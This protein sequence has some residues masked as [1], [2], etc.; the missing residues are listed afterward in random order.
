MISRHVGLL[1]IVVAVLMATIGDYWF[2]LSAETNNIGWRFW[3][4]VLIYGASGY[5]IWVAYK[6]ASWFEVGFLW[7][8]IGVAIY[9]FTGSALIHDKMP[10]GRWIAFLLAGCAAALW[11]MTPN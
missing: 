5:P 7:T 4:G 2:K 1:A 11:F 8:I 9:I 3:L 10:V 6:R